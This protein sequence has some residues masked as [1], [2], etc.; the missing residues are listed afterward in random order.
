[1]SVQ[2]FKAAVNDVGTSG[3]RIYLAAPEWQILREIAEPSLKRRDIAQT[4]HLAIKAQAEDGAVIDW[5]RVN[6]AILARW[7]PSSLEW[8]KKQAWSGKCF[9][10]KEVAS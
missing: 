4:Y 2:D 5:A 3:F 7:S 8:I 1:M 9:A 6:A 10:P